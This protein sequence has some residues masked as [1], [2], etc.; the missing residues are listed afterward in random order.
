MPSFEVL[1]VFL[2]LLKAFVT[3]GLKILK[4]VVLFYSEIYSF[5]NF[6]QHSEIKAKHLAPF[7]N[8]ISCS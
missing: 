7:E 2:R 1:A 8:A 3:E 4:P 6:L 5:Q